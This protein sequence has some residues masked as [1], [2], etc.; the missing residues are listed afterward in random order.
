MIFVIPAVAALIGLTAGWGFLRYGMSS[1]A[2]TVTVLLAVLMAWGLYKSQVAQGW[3]ALA[4]VVIW[5][6][7]AAPALLGLGL[8]ALIGRWRR[9]KAEM[10]PQVE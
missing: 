9:I 3:D 5:L 1:A 10:V 2:W 7:G 6:L 4:Y 8:G